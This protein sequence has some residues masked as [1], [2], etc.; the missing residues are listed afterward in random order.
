MLAVLHRHQVE[1]GG[2]TGLAGGVDDDVDLRRLH[3]HFGRS[4]GE[5]PVGDGGGNLGSRVGLDG[6]RGVAIGNR[7]GFERG[8]RPPRGNRGNLDAAHQH[9]LRHEVGAHLARANDADADR[10]A[11]VGAG[12]KIA[13]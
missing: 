12:G 13:G 8:V 3:Q 11:G 6:V 4:D 7:R 2:H 9:A 10:G 5:L 1:V